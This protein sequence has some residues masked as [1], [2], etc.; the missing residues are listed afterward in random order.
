MA[1]YGANKTERELYQMWGYIR[2][3]CFGKAKIFEGVPCEKGWET[4]DGFK[5]ANYFRYLRAK[6]KWKNYKRVSQHRNG[7]PQE[8]K[9]NNVSLKR[10][11]K[12]LGYTM[13]NT[14]FTSLSDKCKY[15]KSTHK[16]MFE[17][18]LLGTRDI[19]NILKKRGITI[20][21]EQ[22]TTRLNRG[23]DV[24]APGERFQ[25]KWKGKY[26]SY[27][28]IAE[29]EGVSYEMLKRRNYEVNDIRKALD[30]CREWDGFPT[31][32]FEGQSL[33]KME[34]CEILS[35]RTGIAQGTMKGRFTKHGMNLTFLNAPL[36]VKLTARKTVY[37]IKDGIE[38][39]FDSIDI[40]A[41]TLGLTAGNISLAANGKY[42]HTGG[43]KFRF[44]G[45]QYN[46]SRIQTIEEQMD[47]ARQKMMQKSK[48]RHAQETRHCTVCG[49]D[50]PKEEFR[51]KNFVRCKECVAIAKGIER[52]GLIKEREEKFKEGLLWCIDHKDYLSTN[53][54]YK[55]ANAYRGYMAICKDCMYERV[56]LKK[57]PSAEIRD[58]AEA[59][60]LLKEKIRDRVRIGAES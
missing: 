47:D 39:K 11:V 53:R 58:A 55:N 24:F 41:E 54:F 44:E 12:E 33:R 57:Y 43:Y 52:P 29:M 56:K 16:Y 19:K 17:G 34:I 14:V 1:R 37:A 13:E 5:K 27:K 42:I 38:Q 32:D 48:E 15:S 7:I 59:L 10:K 21:M 4:F 60:I 45:G 26:R 22:I 40:A 35:S 30:Y 2:R 51:E 31:Y 18:Q 49:K 6:V 23:A 8:L 3:V 20:T 28:D 25:I 36:G 50:K 46:T 9:L